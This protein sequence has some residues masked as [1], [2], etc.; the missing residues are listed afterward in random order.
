MYIMMRWSRTSKQIISVLRTQASKMSNVKPAIPEEPKT[1]TKIS[2]TNSPTSSIVAAAFASLKEIDT[3]KTIKK[4]VYYI[5]N[6]KIDNANT[7]EDLLGLADSSTLSKSQALKAVSMLADWATTGKAKLSDFEADPRFLKLCRLLGK[8]NVGKENTFSD[9]STVLGITGDDEA[10]KLISSISLPQ[11]IKVLSTLA[12]KKKRSAT[13]MRSLAFN[14]GR[15]SE[16]LDIKQCADIL[17]ALAVLNFPDEVLMEKVSADL[18]STISTNDRPSVI[19]SI[20]TSMGILRLRDT[21][22]LESISSWL[23]NH[24]CKQH[25]LESFL[26]TLAYVNYKTVNVD[27]IFKVFENNKIDGVSNI[28]TWLDVVWSLIVLKRESDDHLKSVLSPGFTKSVLNLKDIGII[29]IKLLNVN[30]Y[31]TTKTQYK[32]PLLDLNS[33]YCQVKLMRSKDKQA[34]MVSMMDALSTM[35]PSINYVKTDVNTNFGFIIDAECSI[36]SKLNPIPLDSTTSSKAG[37]HKI[38]FMLTGFHDTCRGCHN[39]PNGISVLNTQ[40]AKSL[41]YKVLSIPYTEFGL[42]DTLVNRV[43]YLKENIKLLINEP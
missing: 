7:I 8:E 12:V 34:L 43:K 16:K 1:I 33:D 2:N 26:I 24:E 10:A 39:E 30:G 9:L 19:G 20:I 3:A 21:D 35:L 28:N 32:G 17:Y 22:L 38:A 36:D 18:C 23:E 4:N 40:L 5:I 42:R 31:A 13:L 27:N 25:I 41:G 37:I 15:C 11:M 14:I 29:P 6:N